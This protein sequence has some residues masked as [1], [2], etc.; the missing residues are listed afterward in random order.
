VQ[1]ALD[2]LIRQVD[3]QGGIGT[4][5]SEYPNYAA[6]LSIRALSKHRSEGWKPLVDRMTKRLLSLQLAED[7]GWAPED[8]EYGGWDFGAAPPKK[9]DTLRPDISVTAFVLEAL[10]AAGAS[11]EHPAWSRALKFVE[12]CRNADGGFFFTPHALTSFQNKAGAG[13]RGGFR[14]Y[15]T[16]T[17]DGARALL[18]CGVSLQD[19][20]LQAALAWLEER[21]IADRVPG[22]PETGS[23]RWGEGIFYYYAFAL[24]GLGVHGKEI[25]QRLRSLQTANGSWENPVG[26][27]KEDD[28]LIATGLA[29][30]AL[31]HA[32]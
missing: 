13:E 6:A 15:G 20:R 29:L 25:A 17:C 16:A 8:P 30:S 21:R 12:R 19:T 9:P 2:F 7:L 11:A 26:L 31:L 18:A 22:F 14:S 23:E 10:R 28:P 1:R 5:E 27:M 24:G 4:R 32:R 3:E